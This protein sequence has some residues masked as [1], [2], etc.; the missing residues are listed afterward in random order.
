MNC[1]V[2]SLFGKKDEKP[3]NEITKEDLMNTFNAAIAMMEANVTMKAN[4]RADLNYMK[5]IIRQNEEIIEQL[6]QLNS[7]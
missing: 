6:K 3:K 2:N 1:E 4:E 5:I 7:K